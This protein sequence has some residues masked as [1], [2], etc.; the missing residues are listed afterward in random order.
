MQ[1]YLLILFDPQVLIRYILPLA[2]SPASDWASGRIY[3]FSKT[4]YHNHGVQILRPAKFRRSLHARRIKVRLH[5]LTMMRHPCL[6]IQTYPPRSPCHHHSRSSKQ[7]RLSPTSPP[8]WACISSRQNLWQL[9]ILNI[10]IE[11]ES[12]GKTC[13][14]GRIFFSDVDVAHIKIVVFDV[15]SITYL[16]NIKM[17]AWYHPWDWRKESDWKIHTGNRLIP[18]MP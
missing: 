8:S 12:R 11:D 10:F 1:S 16:V 14:S 5:I 9:E 13:A 6:P 7:A 17:Q 18:S 2:Q 4:T 3:R 15:K